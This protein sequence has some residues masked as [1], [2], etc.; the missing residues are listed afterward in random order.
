[1]KALFYHFF[2]IFAPEKNHLLALILGALGVFSFAPF[3]FSPLILISLIG[4]FV[5]WFEAKSRYEA[6]KLGIWFGFGLFGFGVSWLFSSIYV[7]SGVVLPLAVL[8]TF[9]FVFFLSLFLGFSGWLAQYFNNGNRP[10]FVLVLLFPSAWLAG[11]LLRSSIL[12]GYPFLLVGNSHIHTWLSGYAPVFGVWGVSWAVAITAGLLVWLYLKRAWLPVSFSLCL[13]WAGGG[14]L[15][16]VEWVKPIDKSIDVALLQGNIPQ[17]DK[18]KRTNFVP[19][20]TSYLQMTKDN[21]DAD[22]VVWPET[23]IPAYYDVVER[24]ILN[25]F[26]KDAKLLDTDILVGVIAGNKDS[27]DYYNALIN[28]H[29]PEDRYYKHHLVPFSEFFP[30][31]DLFAYL[32]SLFDIP[33]ATFS[34]GDKNQPPLMLGG[35]LAGLS[36]CYEMAF[37]D[38]LAMQ[39]P[40]AKYLVTVSNDAWF[41]NTFEPAQQL[42]EVQVRALELG[43]EIARST[44]TGFTAIIDI[45]GNIK[46]Q[47]APYQ[48]GVLR[49]EVQPYEGL[50]FYAEWG[51]LPILFMIFSLFGFMLAKRYFL[52]GRF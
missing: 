22:L 11:E 15:S 33:Y 50:T 30:F 32:S 21:L 12:G 51:K 10:G 3:E 38:E 49:G 25:S 2:K 19:T 43:R 20:L 6:F 34:H 24:G 44:N 8:M 31:S 39:L 29:K 9:G 5:L 41:A 1:M 4:L 28:V 37:G 7:Y 35:Q 17:Q 52:T 36:I 46:Q 26:I 14:L 45:K 47:I 13:L 48:K 42:Q 16:D 40:D 27:E 18:W 23:A